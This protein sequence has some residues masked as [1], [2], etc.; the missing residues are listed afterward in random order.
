MD[1]LSAKISRT[2]A[3][4]TV[5][6]EEEV[7]KFKLVED[8]RLVTIP[9]TSC[10]CVL[11]CYLVFGAILFAHWEDWSYLDGAY[12]CFI[13]LMTIGFGDFV[14]GNYYIY[15]IDQNVSASEANA[16]IILGSLYI[17]FGMGLIGMCVNLM[18]EKIFL[19]I[20]QIGQNLGLMTNYGSNEAD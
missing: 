18:Q 7:I 10:L 6:K 5:A 13:S 12:F 1:R 4:P 8:I 14:P 20:K 19:K 17:L 2:S 9:I 11:L 15:N 16:K 3:P